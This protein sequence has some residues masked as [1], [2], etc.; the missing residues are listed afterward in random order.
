VSSVDINEMYEKL[1][2]IY[3]VRHGSTAPRALLYYRTNELVREG[4]TREEA[5]KKLYEEEGELTRAEKEKLKE[6]M[7]ARTTNFWRYAVC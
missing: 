4:K 1:L 3:E 6:P 5:I 2:Q 7:R